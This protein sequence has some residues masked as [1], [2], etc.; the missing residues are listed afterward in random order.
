MLARPSQAERRPRSCMSLALVEPRA[1]GAPAYG[2]RAR[3]RAS[4]R[5]GP[6]GARQRSLPLSA[7]PGPGAGRRSARSGAAPARPRGAAAHGEPGCGGAHLRCACVE[8]CSLS[9]ASGQAGFQARGSVTLAV[10]SDLC[11]PCE[12]HALCK[13]ALG[14]A[15]HPRLRSYLICHWMAG[16]NAQRPGG[17][18][19]DKVRVQLERANSQVQ[20]V[21]QRQPLVVRA[22]RRPAGLRAP[23]ARASPRWDFCTRPDCRGVPACGVPWQPLTRRGGGSAPTSR[24]KQGRTTHLI[25]R[26]Y[27]AN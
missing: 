14:H 10:R 25:Q 27:S 17:P 8:N 12:G 23:A 24:R 19:L 18:R 1:A 7:R 13:C 11:M 6:A 26:R 3:A 9:D 16:H 22:Q 5:G 15:D 20:L 4:G 21:G 2:H